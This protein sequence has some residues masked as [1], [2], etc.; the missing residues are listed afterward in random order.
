MRPSVLL[1]VLVW[2]LE[3]AQQD[4]LLLLT[5]STF[6]EARTRFPVLLVHFHAPICSICRNVTLNLQRISEQYRPL[7]PTF[8]TAQID[9]MTEL[10][11]AGKMNITGFPTLLLLDKD[12]ITQYRGALSN[13]DNWL[14]R[15]LLPVTLVLNSS[16]AVADFVRVHTFSTVLFASF[17][18][19]PARVLEAVSKVHPELDL[20]LITSTDLNDLWKMPV[21]SLVVNNVQDNVRFTY[22]G[23]W[24]ARDVYNFISLKSVR[25]KLPWGETAADYVFIQQHPAL[26]FY[27]SSATALTFDKT[28]APVWRLGRIPFLELDFTVYPHQTLMEFLGIERQKYPNIL[29]VQVKDGEVLK[30][31]MKEEITAAGVTAFIDA[32]ELGKTPRFL[33]SE[34]PPRPFPDHSKGAVLELTGLH[35][36]EAISKSDF[37]ALI[38]VYSPGCPNESVFEKVAAEFRKKD[39]V[40]VGRINGAKNDLQGLLLTSYPLMV[41][42][43]AGSKEPL[44]YKG[45]LGAAEMI[46]FVKTVIG[47]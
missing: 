26:L 47:G 25:V 41:L 1:L 20:A 46:A 15:R 38:W 39:K 10:E 7:L 36:P 32:W 12:D 2:A 13:L 8:R 21:P 27:R 6:E 28:L 33:K 3:L 24:T 44:V 45:L 11:T 14:R 35:Y 37:H 34:W 31:A 42:H 4:G 17:D 19:E 40:L 30:Y 18:S 22:T 9:T 23:N 43:P 16:E 5:D 29:I